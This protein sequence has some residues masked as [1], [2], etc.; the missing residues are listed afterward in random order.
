MTT[1][2][3]KLKHFFTIYKNDLT[4]QVFFNVRKRELKKYGLTIDELLELDI[5][6]KKGK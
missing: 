3:M 6:V 1:C 5:S 2:S 4:K